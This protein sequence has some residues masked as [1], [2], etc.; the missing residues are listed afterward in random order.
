[1]ITVDGSYLCSLGERLKDK[2]LSVWQVRWY[3]AEMSECETAIDNMIESISTSI[4]T[5]SARNTFEAWVRF[6]DMRY[7]NFT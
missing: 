3:D 5:I 2:M 4:E 7:I 1:M 6:I